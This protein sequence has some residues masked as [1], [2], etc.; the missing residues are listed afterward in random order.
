MSEMVRVPIA[1]GYI[2]ILTPAEY[3]TG[4]HR[5]KAIRRREQ[6]FD[7]G[8]SASKHDLGRCRTRFGVR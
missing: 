4:L 7:A 8:M 3:A 6:C 2:L 5:G 1:K